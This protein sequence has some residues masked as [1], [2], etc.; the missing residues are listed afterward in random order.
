MSYGGTSYG[1][2][3]LEGIHS[4][5]SLEKWEAAAG[6]WKVSAALGEGCLMGAVAAGGGPQLLPTQGP[7]GKEPR[8]NFPTSSSSRP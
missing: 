7:V 6:T 4:S 1:S 3:Q 5:Q 2:L 8:P